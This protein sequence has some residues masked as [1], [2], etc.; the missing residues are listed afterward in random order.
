MVGE[1]AWDRVELS[2][3]AAE[4]ISGIPVREGEQVEAGAL[5]VQLDTSRAQAVL[6]S[7]K[8]RAV[9]ARHELERQQQL[10]KQKLTSPEQLDQ[11]QS[12]WEQAKA[13]E[14]QAQLS[15]QRL[16]IRAPNPGRVDAL[17]FEIG[18][19]PAVGSVL[20]VL[21]VGDAP[22]ARL[23]AP[24]QQ[25]SRIAVGDAVQVWVDGRAD[26]VAGQ[27]RRISSDPVFTPFYALSEHE[28]SNLAYL[29]DVTLSGAGDLP[30]GLPAEGE[31]QERTQ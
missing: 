4:P 16:S 3:E 25:R 31:L 5:L 21:L 11:A 10:I 9:E 26:P 19:R 2:N 7:A 23:Y 28:R 20:A 12:A 29:L 8:A 30:A 17:P 13:A 24:E 22:Y 1:L 18:E 27:V 14:E 15:L 6:A